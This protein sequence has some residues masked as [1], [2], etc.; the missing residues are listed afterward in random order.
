MRENGILDI[1]DL[2][3][4][5]DENIDGYEYTPISSKTSQPMMPVHRATIKWIC[6]WSFYLA[7]EAGKHCLN[8]EQWREIDKSQFMDFIV[9]MKM[10]QFSALLKPSAEPVAKP[11]VNKLAEFKRGNK[12]DVALY[13][14]LKDH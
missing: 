1:D 10:G 11:A 8:D 5:T 6:D 7:N 9:M 13:L 14:D 3:A 2:M 12:K 4:T